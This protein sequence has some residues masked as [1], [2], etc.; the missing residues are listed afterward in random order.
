MKHVKALLVVAGIAAF[1]VGLIAVFYPNQ[2][3][4]HADSLARAEILASL[5]AKQV[6]SCLHIAERDLDSCQG[7]FTFDMTGISYT[8][9][10]NITRAM[11]HDGRVSAQAKFTPG[12]GCTL[13]AP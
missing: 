2:Q 5:G 6:C 3:A 8:D 4:A 7:D 1:S 13:I 10:N 9:E 12:L 11:S